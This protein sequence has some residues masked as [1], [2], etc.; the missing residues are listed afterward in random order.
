M[1]S[2]T[3]HNFQTLSLLVYGE[4][5][6]QLQVNFLEILPF[7]MIAIAALYC[8]RFWCEW[9][10]WKRLENLRVA[11]T[12]VQVRDNPLHVPI[13]CPAAPLPLAPPPPQQA[14]LY[15]QG[16]LNNCGKSP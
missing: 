5:L 16:L 15:P 6:S 8:L 3:P 7:V 2:L 1:N 9:R 4:S 13:Q 10:C 11:L 14:P 12:K